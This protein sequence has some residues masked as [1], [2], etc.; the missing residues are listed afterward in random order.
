VH[1]PCQ[2]IVGLCDE[3]AL[4][5]V[6]RSVALPVQPGTVEDESTAHGAEVVDDV[7]RPGAGV[8][9]GGEG[10]ADRVGKAAEEADERQQAAHDEVAEHHVPQHL[11][12]GPPRPVG[13]TTK[14]CRG[15]T[16]DELVEVGA[17]ALQVV[18]DALPVC[19]PAVDAHAPV[20]ARPSGQRRR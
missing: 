17:H 6:D 10:T 9:H 19:P 4:Q 5:P 16:S 20:C 3:A 7:E 12:V 18:K 15:G 14:V 11:A 1:P 8:Q 2:C 13:A